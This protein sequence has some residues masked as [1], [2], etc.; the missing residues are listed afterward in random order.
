MGVLSSVEKEC[1]EKDK[2]S[3]TAETDPSEGLMNV[4]KKL[5]ED[6]DDNMK[7]TINKACVESR[8]KE[9]KGNTEF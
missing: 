7:Q 2:P 8:E 5:Y 9:A 3:Y 1:K 6:G 4:L